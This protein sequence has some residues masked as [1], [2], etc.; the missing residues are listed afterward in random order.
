MIINKSQQVVVITIVKNHDYLFSTHES[1][2]SIIIAVKPP[3][4]PSYPGK[5]NES[6]L[7]Q[8]LESQLVQ[9][10]IAV[11]QA[12]F[13]VTLRHFGVALDHYT[14]IFY[15]KVFQ[16]IELNL[17]NGMYQIKVTKPCLLNK[18]NCQAQFHLAGPV[19]VVITLA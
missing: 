3:N 11:A 18:S 12:T 14:N 4:P 17:Q 8:M 16:P 10:V 7:C 15:A 1:P 9:Q 6:L 19:I 13:W 5:Y 2:I